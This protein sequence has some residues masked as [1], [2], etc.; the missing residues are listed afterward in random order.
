MWNFLDGIPNYWTS[1]T[2]RPLYSVLESDHRSTETVPSS[3]GAEPVSAA[4]AELASRRSCL[5]VSGSKRVLQTGYLDRFFFV[6]FCSRSSKFWT[7]EKRVHVPMAWR[8][9]KL[10][11]EET[12]PDTE[13]ISECSDEWV[14]G[15]LHEVIV[16]CGNWTGASRFHC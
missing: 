14:M 1:Q 15:S 3:S 9:L 2:G 12:A 6:I 4:R 5:Q 11:M 10:R 13:H 8:I 7:K 16:R